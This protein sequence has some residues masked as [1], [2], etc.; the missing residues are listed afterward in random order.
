MKHAEVPV[1]DIEPF[2]LGNNSAKKSVAQQV[3]DALCTTGFMS[4]VGHGISTKLINRAR[5]A[6]L[7]FFTLDLVEKMKIANP[8]EHM[9]RGYNWVG[10]RSLAYTLGEE[11]PPD[12]QEGFA[13]GP[14]D[15]E[16]SGYY[17]RP[18]A[19]SFFAP[20]IWPEQP[21]NFRSIFQDYYLQVS[22]L[23]QKVMS[24]FAVALDLPEFYFNDKIDKPTSVVRIVHYPAQEAA[25]LDN[26]LRAG[27][28]T[29]YGTMTILYGDDT[30][31]GL[32]VRLRNGSWIDVH[33][34]PEALICNVGDL[35]ARWTNDRWISN[36]HRVANPP[37]RHASTNRIAIPFFHNTNHDALI[38]CV[39][40]CLDTDGTAK[41][42]PVLFSD[43]YLKKQ[44]KA[45]RKPSLSTG[46]L[47]E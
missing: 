19:A 1:I 21:S 25:P 8:P 40:S 37:P 33:P 14:F 27:A 4:I 39:P 13:F 20:N 23:A 6:A 9:S 43:L 12:L 29:D 28:H 26:Q 15:F 18:E 42:P 11:T 35:M 10:N 16:R 30:P 5:E 34:T 44:T 2:R 3:D 32:Q 17:A 24:L 36:L 7:R 41:Y 31:G 46:K 45:E 38:E 47:D 22:S